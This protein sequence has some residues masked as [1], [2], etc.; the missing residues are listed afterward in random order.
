MTTAVAP[1][2][3]TSVPTTHPGAPRMLHHVTYVT[4][5][6]EATADFYTRI[7]GM[8][9]VSTVMDDH[10]PST[11]DRTPYF[12]TFFQLADGSTIA[13]FESPGLPAK[14]PYPSAAFDNFNH[15]ALEVPTKD[16]V[17]SWK[18]WLDHNGVDVRLVD[19]GIIY[20]LYFHDPNDVRLEITTNVAL[21]WKENGAEA[22]ASLREWVD[23]KRAGG[24]VDGRL[25]ALIARNG[26]QAQLRTPKNS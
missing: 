23:A 7:M 13:F 20:S 26:H 19:H 4:Y 16:D 8:P 25:R 11:G 18:R 21:S 10:L 2:G 24:D 17:N 9:L 6:S 22:A 14:P 15:L 3:A 5:D 12:H 1:S